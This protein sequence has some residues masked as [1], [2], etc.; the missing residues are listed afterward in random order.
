V[1]V[2]LTGWGMEGDRRR[3]VEAGF[4]HHLVKPVEL[5]KLHGVLQSVGR[6]RSA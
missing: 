1:M 3:T 2:A 4:Q 6:A 5:D